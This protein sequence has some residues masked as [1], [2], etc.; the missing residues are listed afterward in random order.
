[1]ASPLPT[2]KKSV[3]LASSPGR[4]SRIRRDPPPIAEKITERDPDERDQRTVILG[5]ATFAAAIVVITIAAG[6]AYGWSPSQYSIE[7]NN[8]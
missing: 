5:I 2:G 3:N 6:S 8:L 4:V 1:M 7:I